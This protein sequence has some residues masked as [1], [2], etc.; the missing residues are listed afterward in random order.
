MCSR[1]INDMKTV[2]KKNQ[3]LYLQLNENKINVNP[4]KTSVNEY[5]FNQFTVHSKPT[6]AGYFITR[7]KHLV[8]QI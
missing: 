4:S 1:I 8:T 3:D 7:N 6:M 5:D 2:H